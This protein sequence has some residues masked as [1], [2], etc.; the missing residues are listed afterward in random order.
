M[1]HLKSYKIFEEKDDDNE[2]PEGFEYSWN[3]INKSLVYLT[4]LGFEIDKPERYQWD[5]EEEAKRRYLADENGNKIKHTSATAWGQDYKSNVELAKWAIYELRL[6]KPVTINGINRQTQGGYFDEKQKFFLTEKPEKMIDIYQEIDAFCG[7]FDKSYYSLLTKPDGY[8][9]WL[10]VA[11]AVSQDYI[12]TRLDK[13]LNDKVEKKLL[14]QVNNN[15]SRFSSDNKFYTKKFREEFFGN[16]IYENGIFIQTFNWNSVTKGVYN[17]NSETFDKAITSVLNGFNNTGTWNL[18][19]YGYKAEFRELKEED[20]TGLKEDWRIE[21]A[22][23]YIGTK[24]IIVKFDYN[25]VFNKIKEELVK[26][27]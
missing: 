23:K 16:K 12:N 24:A 25:S 4:D 11:S 15:F 20:I 3:D 14:S 10:V 21:K 17:T 9:L 27:D 8:Y 1:K 19:Q 26:K 22:K 6:K 7:H 18:G 13:E 5:Y 2:I